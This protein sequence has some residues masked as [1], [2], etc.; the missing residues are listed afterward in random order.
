MV[1]EGLLILL[2]GVLAYFLPTIIAASRG[3]R[4][5]AAIFM[6]NL[7]LGWTFLGWVVSLVWSFTDNVT[8]RAQYGFS[9][10]TDVP[11]LWRR[12][13][14][15]VVAFAIV[16]PVVFFLLVAAGMI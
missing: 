3:H 4:N 10:A 13:L 14:S 16:M 6:L 2:I 1:A 9:G 11:P 15:A 12:L 5:A 8:E 7:F